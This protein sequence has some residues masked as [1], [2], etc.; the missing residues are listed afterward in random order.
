MHLIQEI[1]IE[2]GGKQIDK[3]YGEWMYIW[4]QMSNKQN[5]GLDKMIGNV[6]NNI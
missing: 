5:C 3:Q 4:S 1:N 6:T 2:I